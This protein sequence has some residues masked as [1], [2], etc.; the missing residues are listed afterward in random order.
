MFSKKNLS[1]RQLSI[2]AMLLAFMLAAVV[3]ATGFVYYFKI[4]PFLPLALVLVMI[5]LITQLHA[6]LSSMRR[7][8]R[9]IR[10]KA[11]AESISVSQK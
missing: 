5:P 6:A 11:R 3:V 7:S 9:M 1:M 2:V 8:K 4:D 10:F